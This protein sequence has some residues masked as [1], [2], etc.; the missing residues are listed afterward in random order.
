MGLLEDRQVLR[1]RARNGG[2]RDRPVEGHEPAAPAH[3]QGQQEASVTCR[4]PRTRLWFHNLVVEQADLARPELVVRRCAGTDLGWSPPSAGC[5]RAPARLPGIAGMLAAEGKLDVS[6][7]TTVASSRHDGNRHGSGSDL[8][9]HRLGGWSSANPA[10][11]WQYPAWAA[12]VLSSPPRVGHRWWVGGIYTVE[13]LRRRGTPV[14][15]H[16]PGRG[17]ADSPRTELGKFAD[18]VQDKHRSWF[19]TCPEPPEERLDGAAD[20]VRWTFTTIEHRLA[21][22][23]VT[24][25]TREP[26]FLYLQCRQE[27][28]V[29][30]G[31]RLHAQI[32][33]QGTGD[34]LFARTS[35]EVRYVSEFLGHPDVHRINLLQS[36]SSVADRSICQIDKVE[37]STKAPHATRPARVALI[38]RA[39]H[40]SQG[41]PQE[42]IDTAKRAAAGDTS[43]RYDVTEADAC[44]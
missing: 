20:R 5:R 37:L 22:N 39:G 16:L 34:A 42:S 15:V 9:K 23:A 18:L 41:A 27:E 30:L 28:A 13:N 3:R 25:F 31:R 6:A 7:R 10:P 21:E 4:G 32:F 29:E 19:R 17:D 36:S 8:G 43:T 40:K 12:T 11:R 2:Q 35:L 38:L 24:G 14:F 1:R 44:S 33:G 26:L